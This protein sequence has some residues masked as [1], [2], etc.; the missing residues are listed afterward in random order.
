MKFWPGYF[1]ESITIRNFGL[2]FASLPNKQLS[3]Q[4]TQLEELECAGSFDI[5]HARYLGHSGTG[6]VY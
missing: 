3:H 4:I 2:N 6:N 1:R 5:P